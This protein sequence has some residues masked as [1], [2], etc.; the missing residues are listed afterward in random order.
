MEKTRM[1]VEKARMKVVSS[2]FLRGGE[3]VPWGV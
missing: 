1:K 2:F 3:E